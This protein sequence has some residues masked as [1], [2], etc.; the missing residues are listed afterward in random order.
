[1]IYA[2]NILVCS[3]AKSIPKGV[4]LYN[5]TGMAYAANSRIIVPA[6][7]VHVSPIC[8]TFPALIPWRRLTLQKNRIT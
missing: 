6:H 8:L 2:M 5:K 4:L 7:A 3:A 1:M